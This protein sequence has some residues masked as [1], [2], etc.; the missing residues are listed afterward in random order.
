MKKIA[1]LSACLMLCGVPG[2]FAVANPHIDSS[3]NSSCLSCH[4]PGFEAARP[5]EYTMLEATIDAV[6]LTCHVKTECCLVGQKH[7]DGLFIGRSHASD[8]DAADI[9]REFRPKTLPL[10]D[11]RMTCNTCHYHRR[12]EGRDYKLVRLVDFTPEGVA[13]TRLCL[14]CHVDV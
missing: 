7:M 13:W 11:G 12:P 5:G 10:Q 4:V 14:D 3:D 1:L 8:L 9:R 6:C 2:A